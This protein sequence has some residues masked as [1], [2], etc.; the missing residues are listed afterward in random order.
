MTDQKLAALGATPLF[1]SCSKKQLKL[2]GSVTERLDLPAGHVLVRHGAIPSEMSI[3]ISGKAEV[4]VQG[5]VVATIEAGGVVGELSMVDGG[6]ASGTVTMVEAGEAW[7]VSRRGFIPVWEQN[8]DISTALLL[9]VVARLKA[10]N[11]LTF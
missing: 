1:A 2:I 10:R 7:V 4:E 5:N 8:P 9:A 6:Q 11:E 3:L